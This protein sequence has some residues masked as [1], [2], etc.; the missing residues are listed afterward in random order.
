VF[1]HRR[2]TPALGSLL[3]NVLLAT[4]VA[5][6]LTEQPRAVYTV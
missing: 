1:G 2:R 3:D 4:V 6:R 5:G